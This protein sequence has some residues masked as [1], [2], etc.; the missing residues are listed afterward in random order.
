MSSE[1]CIAVVSGGR[2]LQAGERDW[3]S[4]Q[5]RERGAEQ[6][7]AGVEQRVGGRRAGTRPDLA[8]RLELLPLLPV[9]SSSFPVWPA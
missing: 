3:V 7:N 2:D 5:Q 1:S 4:G 8:C 6:E 9:A